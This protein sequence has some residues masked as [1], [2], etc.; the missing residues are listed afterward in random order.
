ML[1]LSGA[2]RRMAN[3]IITSSAAVMNCAPV[4]T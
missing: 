1:R 3:L 2:R 4:K